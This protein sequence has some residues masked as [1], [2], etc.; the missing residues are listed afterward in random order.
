MKKSVD[1]VVMGATGFTGKCVVKFLATLTKEKYCDITWAIAGRSKEKLQNLSMELITQDIGVENRSIIECDIKNVESIERMLGMARVVIN[2]TG[3]HC[4]LSPPIVECCIKTG[5]HYVDISAE[6][7]HILSL[8]KDYHQ[9]AEQ[10]EVLIIPNCGFSSI[11]FETGILYLERQFKGTLNSVQCYAELNLPPW[12]PAKTLL[13]Q[14]TWASAVYVMETFKEHLA[15][16]KNICPPMDSEPEEM[17]KSFFHR[18]QGCT[19]V[20]WPGPDVY[21]AALTQK[22]LNEKTQKSRVHLKGY[23]TSRHIFYYILVPFIFLYY[24]LSYFK[25]FRRLLVNYASLFTIGMVST[26][27]P[28]NETRHN[29]DFSFT[30]NGKGWESNGDLINVASKSLS[31]KVSGQDPYDATAVAVI[32]CAISII[33]EQ[34]RM[35]KG[36]VIMPGAAFHKTDIIDRLMHNGLK[37]EVLAATSDPEN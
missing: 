28:A 5:T 10:A 4:L 18:N 30:F 17:K 20:P 36:G 22:Y 7:F 25:C 8:Y 16:W 19:W 1:I 2:C 12:R 14:G 26:K 34:S 13:H 31:V 15:L 3:P 32:S 27:G 29:M 35:P 9:R 6:I 37:F 23:T 24:Y 11:P 33:K 21:T